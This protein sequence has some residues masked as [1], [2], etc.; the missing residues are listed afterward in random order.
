MLEL[1]GSGTGFCSFHLASAVPGPAKPTEQPTLGGGSRAQ[2]APGEAGRVAGRVVG[3]VAV[4]GRGLGA[5]QAMPAEG[6]GELNRL[7]SHSVAS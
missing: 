7:H 4:P 5:L 2:A 6:L 3:R 1:K